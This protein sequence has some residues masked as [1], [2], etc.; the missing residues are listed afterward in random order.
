MKER[1]S[2]TGSQ[3]HQQRVLSSSS[4]R[5]TTCSVLFDQVERASGETESLREQAVAALAVAQEAESAL[6]TLQALD[7]LSPEPGGIQDKMT[8]LCEDNSVMEKRCLVVKQDLEDSQDF[9]AHTRTRWHDEV[10]A[11][12]CLRTDAQMEADSSFKKITDLE[13]Q[14]TTLKHKAHE[15]R[16]S[17][18]DIRKE[19]ENLHALQSNIEVRRLN[20]LE[21]A[22]RE[23]QK[24][25][26]QES[27]ARLLVTAARAEQA[28]AEESLTEQ[29][30]ETLEVQS[31]LK[32]YQG[33]C[34]VLELEASTARGVLREV[35]QACSEERS[36]CSDAVNL[37]H[38][39]EDLSVAVSDR[40]S[41]PLR[42]TA[43]SFWRLELE[44][45]MLRQP[46]ALTTWLRSPFQSI[47]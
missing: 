12:R 34:D 19:V 2:F 29:S 46:S 10:A 7:H 25:R 37:L 28:A 17:L 6:A 45:T 22:V 39:T 24:F 41:S 32:R 1:Q 30:A 27:N 9:F 23:V 14:S 11:W 38:V 18:E 5:C 13:T 16:T 47:P 36:R 8:K 42:E 35:R 44:D 21:K 20:D 26:K 15:F 4:K 43:L 40:A 33:L 3:H 31:C